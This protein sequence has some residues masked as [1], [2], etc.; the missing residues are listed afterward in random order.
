[1]IINKK[2]YRFANEFQKT[3][4]LSIKNAI[5][6]MFCIKYDKNSEE[7]IL[8]DDFFYQSILENPSEKFKEECTVLFKKTVNSKKRTAYEYL[9][10]QVS[11]F[12]KEFLHVD[13]LSKKYPN[14]NIKINASEYNN[15]TK[16]REIY[17][18]LDGLD[19]GSDF[20]ASFEDKKSEIHIKSNDWFLSEYPN[21]KKITFRGNEGGNNIPEFE[22]IQQLNH[23]LHIIPNEKKY[24][25]FKKFEDLRG[26]IKYKKR[27]PP[28]EAV[29]WG[30]NGAIRVFFH[31]KICELLKEY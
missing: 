11:G 26:Y 25:P 20:T 14:Y 5:N 18:K 31:D 16:K 13:N 15:I 1:M 28:H 17:Q 27:L 7:K 2:F 30:G 22:H 19:R 29:G 4:N 8:P 12:I 3:Q 23:G 21:S 6:K 24:I 9:Y 10:N